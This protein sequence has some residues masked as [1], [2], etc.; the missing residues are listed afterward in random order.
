MVLTSTRQKMTKIIWYEYF[1]AKFTK[2]LHFHFNCFLSP[3]CFKTKQFSRATY[4][5]RS[6]S[7]Y[8]APVHPC[9]ASLLHRLI[10][11]QWWKVHPQ[12]LCRQQGCLTWFLPCCVLMW[13]R[14]W[15]FFDKPCAT[16]PRCSAMG[17]IDDCPDNGSAARRRS[18]NTT[19]GW[20]TNS[21]ASGFKDREARAR[22]RCSWRGAQVAQQDGQKKAKGHMSSHQC[23]NS[24][25]DQGSAR[26]CS[27]R[28]LPVCCW[29]HFPAHSVSRAW[30]AVCWLWPGAIFGGVFRQREWRRRRWR[31]AKRTLVLSSMSFLM[32]VLM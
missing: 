29:F 8:P 6:W 22:G 17:G 23:H 13:L 21:A 28:W 10:S 4:P 7:A 27:A 3:A 18:I 15:H 24:S 12:N 32:S 26:A 16:L 25:A 30:P 11:Y 31:L 5:T 20:K 2:P 9:I 14:T 19:T 1:S